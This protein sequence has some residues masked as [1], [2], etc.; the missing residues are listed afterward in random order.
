MASSQE[1]D[2]Q[3]RQ[4]TI[5]RASLMRDLKR[6]KNYEYRKATNRD[7]SICEYSSFVPTVAV[8]R[9]RAHAA[10]F[11][12]PM[13]TH[14]QQQTRSEGDLIKSV[15][16]AAP[17]MAPPPL[18]EPISPPPS[19]GETAFLGRLLTDQVSRRSS[20]TL[21]LPATWQISRLCHA[22]RKDNREL[23]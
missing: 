9:A 11:F 21:R 13:R 12:E 19:S 15:E 6:S 16:A 22:S 20:L 3:T 17:S 10:E 8:N 5:R 2:L 1:G 7:R 23:C 14:F 4:N 18:T